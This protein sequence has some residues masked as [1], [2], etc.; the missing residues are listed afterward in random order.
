[1]K[2]LLLPIILI[3]FLFTTE[4]SKAQEIQPFNL[5]LDTVHLMFDDPPLLILF[6]P[7]SN[8]PFQSTSYP[9]KKN[10]YPLKTKTKKYV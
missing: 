9:Y 2:Y 1:M 10:I 5:V 7:L 8:R 3:P 6:N 4:K